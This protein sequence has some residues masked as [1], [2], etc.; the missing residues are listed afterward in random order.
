VEFRWNEWSGLLGRDES[1]PDAFDA[2]AE[3]DREIVGRR[4]R[5]GGDNMAVAVADRA[6][7]SCEGAD[8]GHLHQNV[9]HLTS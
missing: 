3:F 2:V 1:N 5:Y 9:L 8:Q 4:R 7:N 6:F